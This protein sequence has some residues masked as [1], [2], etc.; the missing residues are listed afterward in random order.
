MPSDKTYLN[1]SQTTRQHLDNDLHVIIIKQYINIYLRGD[2]FHLSYVS[3]YMVCQACAC[4]IG[5]IYLMLEFK[6]VLLIDLSMKFFNLRQCL[7]LARDVMEPVS[8]DVSPPITI[9]ESGTAATHYSTVCMILLKTQQ[10][11]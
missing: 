7:P 2:F 10:H 11:I 8:L 3:S 5:A 9:G 6:L 1:E 4:I